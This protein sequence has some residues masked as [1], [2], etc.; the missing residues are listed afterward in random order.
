MKQVS[1]S[2]IAWPAGSDDEALDLAIALGFDGIEIAPTKIFAGLDKESFQRARAYRARLAAR[3]LVIPALQAIMYGAA[4]C[5]LFAS[6]STR[7]ALRSHLARIAELASIVGAHACVFGAPKLRDPGDL[8]KTQ[9]LEVA[10]DFFAGVA[11]LFSDAG[12][13]LAFEANAVQYNCRFITRTLDAVALV[14]RI[15]HPGV[16]VQLDT[17]T[18]FSMD[19]PPSVTHDAAPF[20][21][22]FHASEPGLAPLGVTSS[23]HSAVAHALGMSDYQG[24]VSAE[25]AETPAWR[26]NLRDAAQL[27]SQTYRA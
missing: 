1:V 24:W 9:A 15:D 12:T 7:R 25:M 18:I 21:V 16:R 22:H 20:A 19:E 2:N 13:C 6:D 27:I 11:P 3:G 10:A 17:G 14:Q 8:D 5:E 23:N 4:Q 26:Q